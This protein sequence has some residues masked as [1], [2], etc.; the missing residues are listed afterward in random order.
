LIP[1]ARDGNSISKKNLRNSRTMNFHGA[2]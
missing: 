2:S 1:A